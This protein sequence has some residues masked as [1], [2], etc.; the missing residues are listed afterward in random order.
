LL[1]S[2]TFFVLRLTGGGEGG[3]VWGERGGCCLPYGLHLF[4]LLLRING[5]AV[6]QPPFTA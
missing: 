1:A 5:G 4:V 6:F 3:C 2:W